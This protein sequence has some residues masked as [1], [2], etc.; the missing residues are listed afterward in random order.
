MKIALVH[1]FLIKKGGAERVLKELVKMYPEA[2][3]YT[4]LYDQ[5]K[6]GDWFEPTKVR[7]SWLQKMPKFLRKRP[8]LL[9]N[10]MPQA[11]EQFDF[12]GYDLVISSSGA[13]SHGIITNL[14]TKHICY[15][16]SPMRYA[17]DWTHQYVKEMSGGFLMKSLARRTINKLRQWDFLASRRV[18]KYIANSE[19]IQD[20]IKKFY[21]R[22]ST[23]VYPPVEI[24]K[25]K[26][27]KKKPQ[28]F[29]LI[30]SR[31]S[32]YKRID[33]AVELFN[34][35]RR[36]LVVIGTGKQ[37]QHLRD[38]AGPTVEI[39][40]YQD[41]PTTLKFLQEC[42]GVIF[43]GEDDF[44]IVPIEAMACGKPVIAY[45]KGGA[46]ET[47]I[48]G[49]T[50][51][52][53]GEATVES[54]ENALG[55]MLMNYEKYKPSIIRKQAEKFTVEKFAKNFKKEVKKFLKENG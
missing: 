28:D 10:W 29:F 40:G 34:K 52:F 44:G 53:F 54:L 3:I 13:F 15:C 33:L 17:W 42:R 14:D 25:F 24:E 38:I 21:R 47:V 22:E 6:I 36:N 35:V 27:R 16:H 55:R 4:L 20:R 26:V 8:Q 50:G 37:L 46:L 19:N 30:V 49:K 7:T 9:V 2:P 23:V 5:E 12:T 45:A 43:P 41:D 51:E 31:L 18:G 11:I 32:P 48:A 1:D 39:M